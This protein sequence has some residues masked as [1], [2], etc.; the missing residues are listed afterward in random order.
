MDSLPSDPYG[1]K[2]RC[3]LR[4]ARRSS[5]VV[6]DRVLVQGGYLCVEFDS[7]SRVTR[8]QWMAI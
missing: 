2:D 5:S 1:V 6:S 3:L 8:L 4:R 7:W